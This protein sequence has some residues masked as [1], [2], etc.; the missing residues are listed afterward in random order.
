MVIL[1]KFVTNGINDT[2]YVYTLDKWISMFA[3]FI[4]TFEEVRKDK[5]VLLIPNT[6]LKLKI[7]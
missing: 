7:R 4:H 1:K 5:L 3:K 6:S 2:N